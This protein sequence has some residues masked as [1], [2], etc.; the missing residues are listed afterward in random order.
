MATLAINAKRCSLCGECIAT[1]PFNAISEVDGK[2]EIDAGCRMCKLCLKN[3]PE[4][5][6]TLIDDKRVAVDKEA[7]RGILVF[8]EHLEGEIHPVTLELIGKAREL[9]DSTN[10]P[11]YCLFMGD[12]IA[13]QAK[14]LLQYPVEKVFVYEDSALR[15]F[16]VDVYA[17]IFEDCI[18]AVQPST[19]LVG[20]TSVG[21]SLAPRVAA[22]FRTGLTADCT[23]LEIRENTDLVQIRPAFGGNVMA[24]IV[25][26]FSRPQF[27]TVRYKVMSPAEKGA[28]PSG[29]VERCVA[30][31]ARL[32]SKI[33]VREV[34]LNE[35]SPG[36]LE[37]ETLVVA[38]RGVKDKQDLELLQ[39]LADLLGGQL[40]ATR[41]LVEA[42][43]V[44]YSKQIGL[45]GRT[46]K[47]KLII[48]CGVSGAVQFSAGIS[49]SECIV[50][51]NQ[52]R[53]AP[54]LDQAHY[55]VVGDLYE[56]I[57]SLIDRIKG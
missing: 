51:I 38:G 3:C 31:P 17:N 6:I 12:Q 33:G 37:A 27:A 1:C 39:E 35:Q 7:W 19:V 16:R 47:P 28:S 14:S 22:R 32:K 11:V 46:V 45:S 10:Q 26:P 52:D 49:G 54:I 8:V 15:Y 25:T 5:A 9:A 41:P 43:W 40:A 57:P 23:T 24:Q 21:R 4:K 36:I 55:G 56:V 13:E 18:R 53:S 50:A 42:G 29:T 30:S 20:A 44:H 48:T 34:V 2:I